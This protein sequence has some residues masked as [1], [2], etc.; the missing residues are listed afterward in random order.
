M[1]KVLIT[2]KLA[3]EGI[4]LLNSMDGVEAVVKTGIDK[5]ELASIIG[6]HD[7]LIIRSG[8]GHA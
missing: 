2:D 7:G 1:I 5:D 8:K 4:D 3:Q 6:E